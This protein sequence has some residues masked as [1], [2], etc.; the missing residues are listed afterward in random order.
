MSFATSQDARRTAN[1]R[2]PWYGMS[3]EQRDDAYDKH[4]GIGKY[5]QFTGGLGNAVT[6]GRETRF[7]L[8][9][10]IVLS[11]YKNNLLTAEDVAYAL[12]CGWLTLEDLKQ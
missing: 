2:E 9:R 5:E 12:K 8:G 4:Y 3:L 10:E 6:A 1:S 11:E 7:G